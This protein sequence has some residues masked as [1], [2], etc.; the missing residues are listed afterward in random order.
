MTQSPGPAQIWHEL[1]G[2]P[3]IIIITEIVARFSL[4]KYLNLG[5]AAG[6]ERSLSSGL[7][8]TKKP[9]LSNGSVHLLGICANDRITQSS[10]GNGFSLKDVST[11]SCSA[12]NHIDRDAKS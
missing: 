8:M 1:G 7:S 10:R 9:G 5:P 3:I 12:Q 6:T 11:S 2:S 4:P